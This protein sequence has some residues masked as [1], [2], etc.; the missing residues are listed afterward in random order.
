MAEFVSGRQLRAKRQA[1]RRQKYGDDYVTGKVKAARAEMAESE[2]IAEQVDANPFRRFAWDA[3]TV[4]GTALSPIGD[5][6]DYAMPDAAKEAIASGVQAL[7]ETE[8]GQEAIQ[9]AQERPGMMRDLGA[10]GNL[11]GLIPG[12]QAVKG[13][14]NTV[15]RAMPTMLPGFYGGAPG[16]KGIAAIKGSV[17]AIPS[18]ISDA[19]NP[20][21]IA[22]E[23]VTGIPQSKGRETGE[24]GQSDRG[25]KEIS[26]GSAFTLDS[27]SR[28]MRGVPAD[29]IAKGPLGAMDIIDV[30]PAT[31]SKKIREHLF[32]R[33]QNIR[34][35]V[36][37][38]VQ[39]RAINH[40]YSVH[41]VKPDNTDIKIKNPSGVQK[42]GREAVIDGDSKSS[43]V[44]RMLSSGDTTKL[45]TEV[46]PSLSKREIVTR[47]VRSASRQIRGKEP[48]VKDKS[49]VDVRVPT[50]QAWLKKNKK[51]AVSGTEQRDLLEYFTSNGIKA[52]KGKGDDPHLYIGSSHHSKAKEL[53][54]V[55]DFIAINP[56][57]GDV[58]TMLSDGHDLFG[59]DPI[60]GR[61]LVAVLPMQ[62]SNFKRP[63]GSKHK[64][65]RNVDTGMS[66]PKM[67]AKLEKAA[68]DLEKM[69]GI[70]RNSDESPINYNLR[71]IREYEAPVKAEDVAKSARRAGMLTAGAQPFIGAPAAAEEER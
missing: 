30:L 56:K 4:V 31:E 34:V 9:Y 15:A 1:A 35:D 57:T 39:N 43:P 64:A 48:E 13:A 60:G 42:T 51:K 16:A 50:F 67:V 54:G 37:D 58:Y 17:G 55:N 27:M 19:I 49:T 47:G 5:V 7:S 66:D 12:A 36:P 44:L 53:G 70:K 20:K 38:T 46:D 28:Q 29:F 65:T 63:K 62:K 23:R 10:A 14:A 68:D 6:I 21:S 71:V 3:S 33:G 61:S 52:T 24:L 69:S 26:V 8:M 41:G 32:K 45:G 2:R 18:A 22:Y 59:V 40:L 11:L 25:P